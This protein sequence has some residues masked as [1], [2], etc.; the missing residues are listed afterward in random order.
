MSKKTRRDRLEEKGY[1]IVCCIVNRNGQQEVGGYYAQ[2]EN[3]RKIQGTSISNLHKK[4]FG[5]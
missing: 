2:K 1:K 4:V 5:Y 3:N